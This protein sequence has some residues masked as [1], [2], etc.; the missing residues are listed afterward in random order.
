MYNW[1]HCDFQLMI[2]DVYLIALWLDTF[3]NIVAHGL[4]AWEDYG[5]PQ[6]RTLCLSR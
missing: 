2:V 5:F 4:C 6:L 1:E 3:E